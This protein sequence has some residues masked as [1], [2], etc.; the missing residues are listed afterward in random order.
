M[1]VCVFFFVTGGQEEE[2]FGAQAMQSSLGLSTR[3]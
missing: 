3:A 2:G 1:I